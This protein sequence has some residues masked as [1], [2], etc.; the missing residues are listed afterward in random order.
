MEFHE[1]LQELRK[2][3]GLTQ[4]ELAEIL[5]VSRTAVSKWESGKGYP[6]IGSLKDLA[7][8]FGVTVDALLS[9][10]EL[11]TAAKTENRAN[12]LGICDLLFGMTDL[13]SLTLM[14]LPLYP[15]VTEGH[16]TSVSLFACHEFA[17][18]LRCILWVLLI[19]LCTLGLVKILFYKRKREQGRRSLNG[20][21]LVIVVWLVLLLIFLRAPYAAAMAFLLL[22]L[23]G[24]LILHTAKAQS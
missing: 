22:L 8:F 23:Q 2:N 10:E 14:L 6:G 4:E 20:G 11:M 18:P 9:S 7:G 3:R 24:V 16:I 1:K 17:L 13:M 15:Q 21:S 12:L 19:A 5:Y